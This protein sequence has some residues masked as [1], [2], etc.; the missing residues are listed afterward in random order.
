MTRHADWY[1]AARERCDDLAREMVRLDRVAA[2]FDA[3]G[4]YTRAQRVSW[5]RQEVQDERSELLRELWQSRR[6]HV[7]V[8]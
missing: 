8:S 1:L 7:P 3:N 2:D 5:V 6:I 4:E